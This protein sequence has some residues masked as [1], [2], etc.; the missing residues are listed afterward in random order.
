[1]KPEPLA[2]TS[3]RSRIGSP[4][5]KGAR[6]I[7]PTICVVASGRSV[8]RMKLLLAVAAGQTCHCTSSGPT[9]WPSGMSPLAT[10]TSTVG[11]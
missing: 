3:F 6:A 7:E 5:M 2:R 9:D 11:I 8:R 1:M 4:A 10:S